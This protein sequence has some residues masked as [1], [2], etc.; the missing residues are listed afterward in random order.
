MT[1]EQQVNR[2]LCELAG[3]SDAAHAQGEIRTRGE[4]KLLEVEIPRLD[5]QPDP[6][7]KRTA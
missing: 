4:F 3:K 2:C 7:D 6:L 5:R 1:I